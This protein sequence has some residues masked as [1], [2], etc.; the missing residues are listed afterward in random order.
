M[1]ALAVVVWVSVCWIAAFDLA[2]GDTQTVSTVSPDTIP[3]VLVMTPPCGPPIRVRNR[4]VYII[5]PKCDVPW[6][7]QQPDS[8]SAD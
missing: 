8:K 6:L 4:G 3:V 7:Q 1:K 2:R 5:P